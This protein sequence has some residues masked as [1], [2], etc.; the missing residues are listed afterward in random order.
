M[1]QQLDVKGHIVPGTITTMSR[2]CYHLGYNLS[3]EEIHLSPEKVKG[4][5]EFAR[6][7]T[8]RKFCGFLGLSVCCRLGSMRLVPSFSLLASPL[9]VLINISLPEYL[10]WENK[11]KQTL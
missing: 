7:P 3:T 4:I 9:Y 2:Y 1:L 6:P 11:Q 8:K 10:P 5:Q